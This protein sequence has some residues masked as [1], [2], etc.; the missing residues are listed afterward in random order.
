[1]AR[2]R[3]CEQGLDGRQ[4]VFFFLSARLSITPDVLRL[5]LDYMLYVM[6]CYA[7]AT[8]ISTAHF[9]SIQIH[10]QEIRA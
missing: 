1:M 4:L 8:Y 5:S 10:T 2:Y 6:L 7:F 3:H 9:Y